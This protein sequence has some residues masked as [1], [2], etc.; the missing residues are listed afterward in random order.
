MRFIW[1]RK[2]VKMGCPFMRSSNKSIDSSKEK[3]LQINMH[4][5]V[6]IITKWE[7]IF[8]DTMMSGRINTQS[9]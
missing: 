3:L 2:G 1:K 6:I 9:N 8:P 4:V 7:R 5:Q